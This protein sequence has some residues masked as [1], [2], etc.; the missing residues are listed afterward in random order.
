[1]LT[2]YDAADCRR[3]T[4]R[5][6]NRWA[7]IAFAASRCGAS[8]RPISASPNTIHCATAYI[9]RFRRTVY[10]PYT[11]SKSPLFDATR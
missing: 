1:M 4:A 8:T 5:L 3:R 6:P 9:A 7:A 10:V 11:R 2:S